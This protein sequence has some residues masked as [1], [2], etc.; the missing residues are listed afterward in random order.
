MSS[1]APVIDGILAVDVAG[2]G[3]DRDDEESV[4][5]QEV[6]ERKTEKPAC[7]QLLGVERQYDDNR[8]KWDEAREHLPFGVA[9]I[10][11]ALFAFDHLLARFSIGPGMQGTLT[12]VG[13]L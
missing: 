13:Q 7:I 4:S 8:E 9:P 5:G 10:R 2:D 3:H 6:A 11:F 1:W 12:I